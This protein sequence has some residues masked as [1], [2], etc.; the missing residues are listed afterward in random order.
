MS[1]SSRG[2]RRMRG[3]RTRRTRR[4]WAEVVYRDSTTTKFIGDLPHTWVGSDYI[5]SVL[6]MLACERESDSA[7]VLGAGI[8]SSWVTDAPGV[9]VRRLPTSHGPPDFTMRANGDTVRTTMVTTGVARG[10]FGVH[11]PFERP[12][13]RA[14]VSG[15]AATPLSDGTVVV[16]VARATVIVEY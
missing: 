15:A 13:R 5:R 11:S 16:R 12:I 9:V 6:D 14:M 8:V 7:L 2:A 4:A 3:R 1:I 10:G